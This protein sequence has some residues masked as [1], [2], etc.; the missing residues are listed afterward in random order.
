MYHAGETNGILTAKRKHYK[1]K[2]YDEIWEE[3]YAEGQSDIRESMR[4]CLG[5]N[6]HN[7]EEGDKNG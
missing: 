7:L 6:S 5:L 1:G 3:A 4:D 2:T